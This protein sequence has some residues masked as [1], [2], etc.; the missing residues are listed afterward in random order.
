MYDFSES[1]NDG[2]SSFSSK[3]GVEESAVVSKQD[4]DI[5]KVDAASKTLGDI[6]IVGT[7]I[8][9]GTGVDSAPIGYIHSTIDGENGARLRIKFYETLFPNGDFE[10]GNLGDTSLNGWSITNDKV[11][12]GIDQIGG[13]ISGSILIFKA[14]RTLFG[15]NFSRIKKPFSPNSEICSSLIWFIIKISPL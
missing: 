11:Q 7:Q 2:S 1:I 15:R 6:S 12:L 14:W 10:A 9:I 3:L 13:L 4:I 8:S 5:I